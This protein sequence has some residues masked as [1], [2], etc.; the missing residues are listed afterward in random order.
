ME[1]TP[2]TPPPPYSR[3]TRYLAQPSGNTSSSALMQ[4]QRAP[5]KPSQN[6]VPVCPSTGGGGSLPET[7]GHHHHHH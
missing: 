1:F 5:Q 3:G 4:G 6:L 2:S 7:G